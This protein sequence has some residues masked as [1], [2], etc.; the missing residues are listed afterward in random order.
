MSNCKK[1][2]VGKFVA[3]AAVGAALGVLFAPK[4]GKESRKALM[5]KANDL[6]EKAK[7][8]DVKEVKE[9][10]ELKVQK[11]IKEVKELDKEKVALIAKKKA[12]ELKEDAEEL[13]KYAKEKSTPIVSD[14]AESL[15]LKAVDVTK[16]VLNK[17]ENAEKDN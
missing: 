6:L 8:I 4:S 1:S 12:K 11:L 5:E 9:E 7:E 2:G 13:V 3:G 16:K 14:A 10:L 17:L 15:R